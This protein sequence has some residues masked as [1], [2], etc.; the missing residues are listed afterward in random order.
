MAEAAARLGL[1]ERPR[2]RLAAST[3]YGGVLLA[4]SADADLARLPGLGHLRGVTTEAALRVF[5]EAACARTVSR[6]L[7]PRRCAGT[8]W[9]QRPRPD[10]TAVTHAP[11]H[12]HLRNALSLALFVFWPVWLL[13]LDARPTSA[14]LSCQAVVRIKSLILPRRRALPPSAS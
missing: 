9:P 5:D 7:D 10:P 8:S 11:D 14:I 4:H 6:A 2:G 12:L 3:L 13:Q 1:R